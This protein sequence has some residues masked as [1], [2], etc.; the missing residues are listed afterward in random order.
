MPKEPT[1]D[2][3]RR[4]AVARTLFKPTTLARAI[5]KL[6]FV[7]ADP[8]RAPARAQDLTLRHR[9]AGY[10]AGDLERRYSRLRIDEDAFVNY[11]FLPR[12]HLALLHPRTPRRSWDAA[13]AKKA[14]AVLAFVRAH[15]PTHPR[16]VEAHFAHGRVTN[17]W[18]GSSNATTH[19]LDAM[20][21]RGLLRVRRREGGT[22]VYE[23]VERP[24]AD[25]SPAAR[26]ARA[27]ALLDLV[28]AKYAPLPAASLVYLAR[29]LGYGAPHLGDETRHALGALRERLASVR[30]DNVIWHW[31]ADENP[32]SARHAPDERVRLLA[33]FD[34]IVWDR[35]R[36]AL[37]WG[38]SYRFEA[39]TPAPKRK[40]GYYALPLLWRD[41]VVGWAN[42]SVDGGRLRVVPGYVSGVPGQSAFRRE[43]AAERERMAEFLAL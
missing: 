38:W 30:V 28:V 37:L 10:H 33:P 18:G 12:R 24:P 4:Y 25:D 21:Y 27:T 36:F 22:R 43:F 26:A 41:Q 32:R 17:Y 9:V 5:D 13:T 7:Q 40:L 3:L 35:R 16:A 29:L 42:A 20:H 11:G 31:P 14:A 8:I 6:G 39:Y 15:G 19:L 1:L 23:A 34:P 2:D